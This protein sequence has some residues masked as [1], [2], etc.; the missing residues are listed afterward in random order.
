MA[1]DTND[2]GTGPGWYLDDPT[3]P[4]SIVLCPMSCAAYQADVDSMLEAWVGCPTEL[5]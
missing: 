3:A 5:N 1:D 4:T 2:C